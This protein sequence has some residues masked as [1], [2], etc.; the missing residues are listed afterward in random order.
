[1]DRLLADEVLVTEAIRR[2]RVVDTMTAEAK[3]VLDAALDLDEHKRRQVIEHVRIFESRHPP[4]QA[5]DLSESF[6]GLL[7]WWIGQ[8]GG[9][10]PS[11]GPIATPFI[12]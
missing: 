6:D 1:M 3:Q 11:Q 7:L 8:R 9:R 10:V 4:A 2:A 5:G 12:L